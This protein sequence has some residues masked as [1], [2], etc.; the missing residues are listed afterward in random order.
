M[1]DDTIRGFLK[2]NLSRK[3]FIHSCNVADM[4]AELARMYGEDPVRA[5]FAGLTHDIAKEL[6]RRKQKELASRSELNV[7]AVEL[8]S[9]PL[10]HA[11]AGAQLLREKFGIADQE[12]LLAV[13]YHTVGAG[14]MSKLC[15]II[16]LADLVSAD[17]DY[18][19]VKKMRKYAHT[20]LEKGMLEALRFSV[21]D[22]AEKGNTIPPCTIEAY[23]E[24][25]LLNK[26]L[27]N[28]AKEK[29]GEDTHE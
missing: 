8:E 1:T 16:Y 19:D 7:S 23:N 29:K 25:A 10:L 17:R 9:P 3:R 11:I 12:I 24:F 26:A 28:K 5:R 2:D 22:S 13:R 18:K 21:C 15:Q 20:S 6:P 14:G 27:L 4:A